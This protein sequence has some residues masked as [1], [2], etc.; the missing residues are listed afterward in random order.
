VKPLSTVP[1]ESPDVPSDRE[2]KLPL[3][4]AGYGLSAPAVNYDDYAG[5]NVSGK[6]VII[7]SHEPQEADPNSPLNGNRPMAQTTLYQKA[8]VAHGLG[9]RALLAS[10]LVPAIQTDW[11]SLEHDPCGAAQADHSE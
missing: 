8:A 7:F 9:A 1:N 4:F 10:A 2:E 6:A 5:Q 11:P 3:V